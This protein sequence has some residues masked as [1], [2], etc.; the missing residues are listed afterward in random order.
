MVRRG[1]AGGAL[2]VFGAAVVALLLIFTP[3]GRQVAIGTTTF[4]SETITQVIDPDGGPTPFGIGGNKSFTLNWHET[5]G[6]GGFN[7]MIGTDPVN[8]TANNVQLNLTW[9]DLYSVDANDRTLTHVNFTGPIGVIWIIESTF[10]SVSEVYLDAF[11]FAEP[12]MTVKL[13]V[14]LC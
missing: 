14:D 2:F 3:T 8:I 9:S 11:L 10:D 5:G 12:A 13:L 7:C 1:Q 4:I 6:G